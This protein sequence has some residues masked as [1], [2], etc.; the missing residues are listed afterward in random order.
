MV[1]RTD[2]KTWSNLW[3]NNIINIFP[4]NIKSHI[5][6]S[7]QD[8]DCER[9]FIIPIKRPVFVECPMKCWSFKP[10]TRQAQKQV[11]P[12]FFSKKGELT[13]YGRL[14]LVLKQIKFRCINHRSTNSKVLIFVLRGKNGN[15]FII[16]Q[17]VPKE[18]ENQQKISSLSTYSVQVITWASSK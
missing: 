13:R 3:S 12:F 8:Q 15:L 14:V 5:D 10:G 16:H 18:T 1:C 11:T 4:T 6:Y 7:S 17:S 2:I 9:S